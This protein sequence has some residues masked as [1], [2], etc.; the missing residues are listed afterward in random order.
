MLNEQFWQIREL[1]LVKSQIAEFIQNT[2][3]FNSFDESQKQ[4]L[5]EELCGL[6][7]SA[8]EP[9]FRAVD[10]DYFREDVIDKIKKYFG[11]KGEIILKALPIAQ[12]DA[13]VDEWQDDLDDSCTY[14]EAY[15]DCLD[16]VIDEAIW[17]SDITKY[18]HSDICLYGV[19]LKDWYANHNEGEPVCIKEF[20]ACEMQDEELREYYI[21]L[22]AN[23]RNS[24]RKKGGK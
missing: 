12:I 17:L 2:T 7:S 19:Y 8:K 6:L 23:D 22:L 14:W 24:M 13:V 16:N 1:G 5:E 3:L 10:R 11:K 20:F 18:R 9:I 4:Q 21:N 15:W